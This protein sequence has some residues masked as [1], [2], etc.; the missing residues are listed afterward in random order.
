MGPRTEI[1]FEVGVIWKRDSLGFVKASTTEN[2]NLS[3]I[4]SLESTIK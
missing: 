3:F 1:A 4:M 2:M